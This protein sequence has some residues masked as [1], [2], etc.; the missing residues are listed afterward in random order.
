MQNLNFFSTY[1]LNKAALHELES[2][3]ANKFMALQLDEAAHSMRNSSA[4][5]HMYEGVE[6]IDQ[7]WVTLP[8]SSSRI[9][10]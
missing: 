1:R 9:L 4:G 8:I 7:T 5:I 2:D 10:D 6:C 3:K